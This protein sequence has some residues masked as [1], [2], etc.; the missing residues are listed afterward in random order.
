MFEGAIQYGLNERRANA[1]SGGSNKSVLNYIQKQNSLNEDCYV[2]KSASDVEKSL[3]KK[4]NK[5]GFDKFVTSLVSLA[6]VGAGIFM[7]Y[8][9]PKA[10]EKLAEVCNNIKSKFSYEKVK[11]ISETV[12]SKVKNAGKAATD[13][14]K[15]AGK[16][17][18]EK[19]KSAG[20]K[21]SEKAKGAKGSA[22]GFFGNLKSKFS[23][24]S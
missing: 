18:S 23:K 24:K 7:L 14:A 8:K 9:N 17:V 12:A 11:N 13:K 5:K 20:E 22:K 15:N 4:Q 10:K 1:L 2:G 16:T 6:A 21:A 19:A 3:K